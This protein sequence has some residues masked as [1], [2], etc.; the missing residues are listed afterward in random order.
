MDI[1]KL[2]KKHYGMDFGSSYDIH[3]ID[4]NKNN[5]DI[6]NLLLLPQ[7]LHRRFHWY[8]MQIVALDTHRR[9]FPETLGESQQLKKC[10]ENF[11]GFGETLCQMAEWAAKKELADMEIYNKEKQGK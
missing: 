3:H 7:E 11:R 9:A 8:Y 10:G 4:L 5:N 1:R 6:S 2:Y